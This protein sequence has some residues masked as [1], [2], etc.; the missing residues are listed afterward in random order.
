MDALIAKGID[1]LVAT[2]RQFGRQVTYW[3]ATR[4][5]QVKVST[6]KTAFQ[7]DDGYGGTRIVWTDMTFLVP[8]AD[9][10]ID[11]QQVTPQRHDIIETDT[12]L[13][14]EVLAPAGQSEWQY[15][16][17]FNKLIRIHTMAIG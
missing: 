15:V 5:I 11:S 17:P 6:S 16:D 7:I 2:I 4:P 13:R 1:L 8:A 12:G 14:Y 9:L 10:V 3:W